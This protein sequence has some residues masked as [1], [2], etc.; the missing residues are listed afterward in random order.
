MC[1]SLPPLQH[2]VPKNPEPHHILAPAKIN[3]YLHVLGASGNYHQIES[4]AVFTR[5]A[6]RLD[7]RPDAAISLQV[8][9]PFAAQC[10]PLNDNLVLRA[11][12]ALAAFAPAGA[13]AEMTLH[14]FLPAA[15]GLGGGSADAA[16]ALTLLMRFW[17][18]HIADDALMQLALGLGADVTVCLGR[19]P[20][21]MRGIGERLST[22]PKLPDCLVLLVN[23]RIALSTRAVFEKL[24]GRF[25]NSPPAL[26]R[27]ISSVKSLA[28]I[29][30]ARHNDLQ[31]PAME[32]AP[33]ISRTLHLLNRQKGCLLAR[34]SGSGATCFGLFASANLMA[35]AAAAISQAHPEYWL[36]QTRLT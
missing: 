31:L 35:Q 8:T 22:A 5:L 33:E 16:A 12:R 3:L 28:R 17:D 29:L 26:P 21:I 34:M 27:N 20:A 6:D 18:L 14:K 9:G 10:G 19:K 24:N 25:S 7:V 36:A 2:P 23:P 1:K 11:A 4:L 30:K 13:G 15:G 32:I